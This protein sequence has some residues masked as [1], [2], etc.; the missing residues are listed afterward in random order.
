M[1]VNHNNI[2]IDEHLAIEYDQA[3]DNIRRPNRAGKAQKDQEDSDNS[4]RFQE[5]VRA[6]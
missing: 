6:P 3:T 2:T 1:T 4:G 5:A